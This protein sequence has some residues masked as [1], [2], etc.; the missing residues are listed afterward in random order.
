[1]KNEKRHD[2]NPI[3]KEKEKRKSEAPI[4]QQVVSKTKSQ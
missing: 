4:L 3:K 1:M 2:S